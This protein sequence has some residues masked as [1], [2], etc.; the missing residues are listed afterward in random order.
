M[1][2]RIDKICQEVELLDRRAFFVFKNGE[3]KR[4]KICETIGTAVYSDDNIF[5]EALSLEK[6]KRE[7][8]KF[9]KIGRLT[10][11]EIEKIEK[12]FSKLVLN[13]ELEYAKVYGKEL[14]LRDREL[15]FQILYKLVLVDNPYLY[16]GLMVLSL[17]EILDNCGWKDEIWYLVISYLTKQRADIY[18]YENISY[19]ENEVENVDQ[20]LAL[21]IYK[22]ILDRYSG[23]DKDRFKKCYNYYSNHLQEDTLKFRDELFKGIKERI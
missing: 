22:K 9:K 18:I 10:N 23:D 11:L 8:I 7:T 20:N 2:E 16:K 3:I 12:N 15:F 13:G 5:N 1:K 19:F 14:A 21:L 17:K 4:K 6:D